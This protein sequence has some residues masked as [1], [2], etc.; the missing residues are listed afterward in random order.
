MPGDLV[1][2]SGHFSGSFS[3]AGGTISSTH[4]DEPHG[5]PSDVMLGT[6]SPEGADRWARRFGGE[7]GDGVR[8]LAVDASGNMVLSGITYGPTEL[9]GG[10][11]G[12]PS[13]GQ[14][15]FI[16]RYGPDGT[17]RWSRLLDV[18]LDAWSLATTSGGEVLLG[19]MFSE[20]VEVDGIH[21]T[22]AGA[23]D[24]LLLKFAP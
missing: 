7:S 14:T 21:Y 12:D 6:L 22:S 13:P 18:R 9:G 20:P 2:F 17:H 1:A 8:E 24:V 5:G 19:G 3:F 10:T 4:P 15:S 11:L 23:R 16:A